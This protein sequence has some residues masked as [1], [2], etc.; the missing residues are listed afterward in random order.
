MK[1]PGF[2]L[3]SPTPEPVLA[4]RTTHLAHGKTLVDDYSWLRA[5]NWQEVLKDPAALP[6][7]IPLSESELAQV[8][9]LSQDE[10]T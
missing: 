2:D 9:A 4:R 7:D 8:A 10:T 6:A 3:T 1:T 5:Q